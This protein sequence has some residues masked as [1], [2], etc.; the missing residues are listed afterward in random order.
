[1]TTRLMS[2]LM[3]VESSDGLVE[4]YAAW[5]SAASGWG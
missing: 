5:Q 1:M 4:L 2:N 3:Q